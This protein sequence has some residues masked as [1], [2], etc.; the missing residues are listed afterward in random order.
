MD[1]FGSVI[2][3]KTSVGKCSAE[4]VGGSSEGVNSFDKIDSVRVWADIECGVGNFRTALVEKFN[5]DKD[6]VAV[7]DGS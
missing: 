4:L 2:A 7:G 6:A 5:V 1:N 3:G